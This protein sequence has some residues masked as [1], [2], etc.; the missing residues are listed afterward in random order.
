MT[1]TIADA[2]G[3]T[4]MIRKDKTMDIHIDQYEM[5]KIIKDHLK[6]KIGYTVKIS[7]IKL[8]IDTMTDSFYAVVPVC[9]DMSQGN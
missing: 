4:K 6:T 8:A 3:G 7:D 9:N 5:K 1:F 2:K